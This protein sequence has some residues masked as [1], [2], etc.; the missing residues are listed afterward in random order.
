[1]PRPKKAGVSRRIQLRFPPDLVGVFDSYSPEQL[2]DL[3]EQ[4]LVSLSPSSNLGAKQRTV[5]RPSEPISK[6][7]VRISVEGREI[8]LLFPE[9]RDDFRTVVK[10]AHHYS[11][12]APYWVRSFSEEVICDRAAEI[13]DALLKAGFMVQSEY[14]GVTDAVISGS[15]SPES[16]RLIKVRTKGACQ[17]WFVIEWPRSED[18]WDEA[19]LITGAKYI[20]KSLLVPP[21]IYEEVEDFA[22][23]YDFSFTPTARQV[24]EQYKAIV[25]MGFVPSKAGRK[26]QR[27]S[28]K[29]ENSNSIPESLIDD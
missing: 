15:F 21:E 29:K 18:Y 14:Q 20:D 6:C 8:K 1:M 25:S 16:L 9:K 2:S 27:A 3:M 10:L 23:S 19:N 13:A 11:W 5:V 22:E 17:D 7:I 12:S 28:I 4:A 24:L 26:K